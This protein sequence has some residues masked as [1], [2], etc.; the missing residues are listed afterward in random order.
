MKTYKLQ[1]N[2]MSCAACS[3]RIEKVLN[4]MEGV[5]S[6]R[7]NLASE[8]GYVDTNDDQAN[9]TY[10]IA[11]IEKIG[12]GASE[13]T[14]NAPQAPKTIDQSLRW[15]LMICLILTTPLVLPM[16]AMP[17][18]Q[19]W[20]LSGWVQFLLATPVQAIA[21]WR[22][23]PSAW[24]SVRGLSGNMDLLVALG[25]TAAYGL[26]LYILLS[27]QGAAHGYYFEASA[28]V[29]SLILLGKYLESRAKHG[30]GEAIHALMALKPD[31]ATRLDGLNQEIVPLSKIQTGDLILV[32][33]GETIPV[34]GEVIK[35]TSEV[36]ESLINGEP[37][38]KFK[39][40][41]STVTGGS[42]NGTGQLTVKT[43]AIGQDSTLNRIIELI[44]GAQASKA[45]IQK[46][47]DRISGIFVPVVIC[48]AVVTFI[49][50][51]VAGATSEFA[52]V[53]AI[54]V[55][56]IACPCALGLATPSAIIAGTG[57]AAKH[58]ILIKDAQALETAHRVTTVVFDKT[59]TLTEGRPQLMDHWGGHLPIAASL[60]QASEHPIAKAFPKDDLKTVHDFQAVPGKGVTA[61]ID[62][63]LYRL[64]N[65]KMMSQDINVFAAKVA[66]WKEAGW[67]IVWLE[68]EKQILGAFAIGDAIKPTA[69]LSIEHLQEKGIVPHLLSGD[70]QAM[71][72]TVASNVGITHIKADVLPS[73]KENYIKE[74]KTTGEETIAMVGDG[75][76]DAPALARADIG[77]AMSS[78][79]DIAMESAPITLMRPDPNLVPM[80]IE[81]SKATYRKIQQNLFWA[82]VYN[83][84]SLPLAAFGLL[85]PVIAGAAMALSSLS[86][87]SNALLLKRWKE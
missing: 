27:T 64:G 8:I 82:F 71:A 52:A 51:L 57:L 58:G 79:A 60:Q 5:Q 16:V 78:G 34:D 33:P 7:I 67:G 37:L 25:T 35:G 74:L 80:A 39:T 11:R 17:F 85:N 38:P 68:D 84:V 24:G 26:S 18:G 70:T 77:F 1:I 22:F 44:Q 83:V 32:K 76:N 15:T 86:V 61:K 75:I 42:I 29:T 36:D 69:H 14:D 45:P 21:V 54:T 46:L 6:A 59:G 40:T 72:S 9:V 41:L 43:T 56:V 28:A 31:V 73:E 66:P 81:I 65:E 12:F 10:I 19:D 4:K 55:L 48:I 23:Y 30:V 13:I 62:G 49:G 3:N 53:T 63:R 47:A 87:V 50:W 2:G 20:H